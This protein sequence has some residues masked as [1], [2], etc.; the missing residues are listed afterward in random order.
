MIVSPPCSV[1]CGT[2]DNQQVELFS[3]IELCPYTSNHDITALRVQSLELVVAS[4]K[5]LCWR[6]WHRELGRHSI[7][8]Q[9]GFCFFLMQHSWIGCPQ[10]VWSIKHTSCADDL[11]SFPTDQLSLSLDPYATPIRCQ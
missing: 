10:N 9:R 6:I 3:G 2:F 4:S 7:P 1:I 8:Y 5:E 11:D